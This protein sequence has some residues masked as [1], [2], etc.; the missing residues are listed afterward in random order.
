MP[1]EVL[2]PRR[3]GPRILHVSDLHFGTREDPEMADAIAAL[4]ERTEP[5]LIVA[6]GDLTHRGR[7]AQHESAARVL[8]AFGLPVL[9]VPGNHDLP[10][11]FPARFTRPWA[12]FE[13]MWQT[14]EPIY[15]SE[16][17][18]IVGLNSARPWRQQ[19]GGVR[20]RQLEW[21]AEHLATA[22]DGALRVV[23]LHHHLLGAPWRSR[24]KPVADRNR[25]LAALVESGAELIL[26]GHIHQGAVSERRE[27]EVATPGGER[28]VTVSIAP[29]LGQ[30]RPNRRGEAR[31]LHVYEARAHEIDVQTYV[32]R[33]DGW[34][35]TAERRFPR[36]REPLA[37]AELR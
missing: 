21:A 28:G 29:G 6:S 5:E 12:E 19:S 16:R 1:P 32:W 13:R 35:L 31:G 3:P 15:R 10:Y 34:A 7:R 26:A 30:P 2:H 23:V 22:D 25:V 4:I 8:R 33:R 9:A 27:F 11:T 24:K 36:G 20:T 17:V 14:T 18:L 37:Y